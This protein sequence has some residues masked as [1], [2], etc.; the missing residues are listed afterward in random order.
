M[1]LL[2][3]CVFLICM[4]A[5]YVNGTDYFITGF[6]VLLLG[7]IGYVLCKWAYKGRVLDNA[8]AY[9]LN[10]KTK[11]GLG[12]LIDIGV[13]I[14]FSGAMALGGAIF[15]FFYESSYGEEYYLEE[16]GTGFFSDFYGM[17]DACKWLGIVLLV[18]GAVIWFIGKKTE[19]DKVQQLQTIRKEELDNTIREIHGEV[20]G[21]MTK[22]S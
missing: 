18:L 5:I 16:Y 21:E 3:T 19:G 8:E 22:A 9:P 14:F 1:A 4:F 20:P 10:P 12:D 7:L 15:L 6:L 17:I 11:L 2:S 13:Y